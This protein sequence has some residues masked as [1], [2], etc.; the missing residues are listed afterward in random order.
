MLLV[1]LVGLLAMPGR[2]AADVVATGPT[3]GPAGIQFGYT[4]PACEVQSGE[5]RWLRPYVDGFRDGLD[6]VFGSSGGRLRSKHSTGVDMDPGTHELSVE[7]VGLDP[8]SGDVRVVSRE[9][10]F[11]FTITATG[12]DAQLSHP[13][14]VPTLPI[15]T[16]TGAPD[17]SQ[18]CPQIEG[19]RFREVWITWLPWGPDS[20]ER[21]V[22][23]VRDADDPAAGLDGMLRVPHDATPGEPF[24]LFVTCRDLDGRG[25][26]L[27]TDYQYGAP[28]G[29]VV[30]PARVGTTSCSYGPRRIGDTN[31]DGHVKVA[32]VGDSYIAG[33]GAATSEHPYRYGTDA[34]S[35]NRCHRSES[36][37]AVEIARELAFTGPEVLD[38]GELDASYRD[39][40][41]TAGFLACS[42]ARTFNLDGEEVPSGEDAVKYVTEEEVQLDQLRRFGE[43]GVDLVLLSIG[44]NDAGFADIVKACLLVDC[45]ADERVKAERVARLSGVRNRVAAVVSKVRAAAPD[46]E[47]YQVNYPDPLRPLP[48]ACGSLGLTSGQRVVIS[49]ALGVITR[50]PVGPVV[51]PSGFKGRI[52]TNEARW[53]S[54]SFLSTLNARIAQAAEISGAH[55]VDVS[56]AFRD[57]EVCGADTDEDRPWVHGLKAGDDIGPI[58]N[59]SFHPS[60]EGQAA[61]ADRAWELHGENSAAPFGSNPNEDSSTVDG[62]R[63]GDFLELRVLGPDPEH[64]VFVASS[65]GYVVIHHADENAVTAV[66]RYSLGEVAARVRTDEHGSARVPIT[67]PA[68]AAGGLHHLELWTESGE[69]VGSASYRV[70]NQPG[71]DGD[72]DLD[73]DG[74]TDRCD[75]DPAD[76]PDADADAD[77]SANGSD[78]CPLVS[79]LAQTDADLD[80]VGDAC[81][82]TLIADPLAARVRS[83]DPRPVAPGAV[84]GLLVAGAGRGTL[85]VTW[86]PP[87]MTGDAPVEGYRVTVIG[88]GPDR[89]AQPVGQSAALPGL[90]PGTDV[91]VTVQ[92]RSAAGLGAVAISDRLQVPTSDATL[93]PVGPPPSGPEQPTLPPATTPTVPSPPPPP[94]PPPPLAPGAGEGVV[95]PTLTPDRRLTLSR[96][97]AAPR[98]LRAGRRTAAAVTFTLSR[99]ASVRIVVRRAARGHMRGGRCTAA[100]RGRACLRPVGPA[101]SIVRTGRAGR[102]RVAL[103]DLLQTAPARAGRYLLLVRAFDTAGTR[104]KP[105][106]VALRVVR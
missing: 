17:G 30:A 4:V 87:A 93:P 9:D 27:D 62:F 64:D 2:A 76:G 23:V 50:L 85:R 43:A 7:C 6:P 86:D 24:W 75:L 89:V 88:D 99:P 5:Q 102:N 21:D 98:R 51:I 101:R 46:A 66:A 95:F 48:A 20:L 59:E 91:Q 103:A 3:T 38:F 49:A 25:S 92:A 67:V 35:V 52:T 10:G 84:L 26:E 90:T 37:W 29:H 56:D 105:R 40:L 32:V 61:L 82:G 13:N 16:T 22:T 31:C 69:R 97:G 58:G 45:A 71:C 18:P 11:S 57:H 15:K 65:S 33:E 83:L 72:P 80:D 96:V 68:T 8:R 106:A 39:R 73:G 60:H 63:S 94:P 81:D 28:G 70:A 19:M 41:D 53:L 1:L 36:S 55:L 14:A 77:G 42:G 44:G 104:S 100:A 12:S 79:N 47:V 74:L 34:G 54:E 78:N